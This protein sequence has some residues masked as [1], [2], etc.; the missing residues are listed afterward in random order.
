MRE[1]LGSALD[2]EDDLVRWT[3]AARARLVDASSSRRF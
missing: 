2:V 1:E 3:N